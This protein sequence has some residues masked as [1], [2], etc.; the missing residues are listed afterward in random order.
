MFSF[1]HFFV[2]PAFS[3]SRT[4]MLTNLYVPEPLSL[5]PSCF[6][7]LYQAQI[8]VSGIPRIIPLT[9]SSPPHFKVLICSPFCYPTFLSLEWKMA[10]GS[11][12]IYDCRIKWALISAKKNHTICPLSVPCPT[13]LES[14]FALS[15]L[16]LNTISPSIL[17]FSWWSSFSTAENTDTPTFQAPTTCLPTFILYPLFSCWLSS[18]CVYL[19]PLLVLCIPSPLSYSILSL[20]NHPFPLSTESFPLTCRHAVIFLT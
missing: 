12:Y 8:P 3:F 6:L 18:L 9:L 4:P 5:T 7:P 20:L 2:F 17:T 15:H 13:P 10:V 1:H 14:Y 19:S 11:F 16:T